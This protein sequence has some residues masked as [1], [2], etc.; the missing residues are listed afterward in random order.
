MTVGQPSFR[1]LAETAGAALDENTAR[2]LVVG[3]FTHVPRWEAVAAFVGACMSHNG[4]RVDLTSTA[5]LDRWRDLYDHLVAF[6]HGT[7]STEFNSMSG[8]NYGTVFQANAVIG[9]VHLHET[10]QEQDAGPVGLP[11]TD[12]RPVED[13]GVHA[14]IRTEQAEQTSSDLPHY[15]PRPHDALLRDRLGHAAAGV[16][17]LVVLYGLS[18]SGKSRAAYEA[19]RAV[20]PGWR[21]F[22]PRDADALV[23]AVTRR[24]IAAHTVMWLDDARTFFDD[25]LGDAAA[26]ALRELLRPGSPEHPNTLVVLVSMWKA[27]WNEYRE[28]TG[29]HLYHLL[30]PA[31]GIAVS[32][33]FATAD[34]V[35]LNVAQ[36]ADPRVREAMT[37]VGERGRLTQYLAGGVFLEDRY[38]AAHG[39]ER[40]VLDVAI[41]AYRAGANTALPFSVFNAATRSY[42]AAEDVHQWSAHALAEALRNVQRGQPT[43][44]LLPLSDDAYL[45][46]DYL[47]H[48]AG[49][50]RA[51][52]IKTALWD[53]LDRHVTNE[54]DRN[55]LASYAVRAGLY[56]L[57]SVFWIR[58]ADG[59][60]RGLNDY[61]KE[62]IAACLSQRRV[63]DP[64][65]PSWDWYGR[66]TIAIKYYATIVVLYSFMLAKLYLLAIILCI[67]FLLFW[68]VRH[69]SSTIWH[70]SLKAESKGRQARAAKYAIRAIRKAASEEAMDERLAPVHMRS[71]RSR[72]ASLLAEAG[73]VAESASFLRSEDVGMLQT[74]SRYR[75]TS[76]SEAWVAHSPPRVLLRRREPAAALAW[77]SDVHEV[78]ATPTTSRSL[79][80]LLG[81]MNRSDEAIRLL[82]GELRH[83]GELPN[84]ELAGIFV[85][86][87]RLPDLVRWLC[88][89]AEANPHRSPGALPVVMDT[90]DLLLHQ[91]ESDE[92]VRLLEA[93]IVPP[94]T[95][96]FS[97]D[98]RQDARLRLAVLLCDIDCAPKADRLYEDL[99]SSTGP[100]A[101]DE[102]IAEAGVFLAITGRIDSFTARFGVDHVMQQA[103]AIAATGDL[104]RAAGCA[105]D[106]YHGLG[107]NTYAELIE[108]AHGPESAIEYLTHISLTRPGGATG[109]RL[110]PLIGAYFRAGEVETAA[111]IHNYGLEPDGRPAA[112]WLPDGRA[113]DLRTGE[114]VG[115]A[116]LDT[117]MGDIRTDF[118]TRYA[119]QQR[120]ATT[121][122][123]PPEPDVEAPH[124]G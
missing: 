83:G 62:K 72:A 119:W 39:V 60:R 81:D 10:A 107:I 67:S 69:D 1:V 63:D 113:R 61:A 52:R 55:R 33:D 123:E 14:A 86:A 102:A 124:Q 84:R 91:G 16:P 28:K 65:S 117:L 93:Y 5:D 118:A 11:F 94:R 56:R 15:L 70:R 88:D 73:R 101:L 98:H 31:R 75:N 92:A 68:P 66:S 74:D 27:T 37:R 90:V 23:A 32:D 115:P 121:G 21:V 7:K 122:Q 106:D 111:R 114:T 26:A 120:Y 20:L 22:Q 87:D 12:L 82:Q 36:E 2:A 116:E 35:L 97:A 47:A 58:H 76:L 42:L 57:A 50:L 110:Y 54:W 24:R 46:A 41:D 59:R 77:L 109:G 105:D 3:S 34:P 43:G 53:A 49:N 99:L 51:D 95:S 103:M 4:E 29:S 78:D 18:C 25:P 30:T 64:K 85:R 9:D 48:N 8:T 40:A 6:T 13:L 89:L 104:D 79:A 108:I 44:A 100:E 17:E 96:I 19:V 38:R 80:E 45:L 71:H 112:V